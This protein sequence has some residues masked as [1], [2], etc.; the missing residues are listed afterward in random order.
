VHAENEKY[1]T[2]KSIAN[3][4]KGVLHCARVPCRDDVIMPE[5]VKKKN[6]IYNKNRDP[7][8]CI[9]ISGKRGKEEKLGEPIVEQPIWIIYFLRWTNKWM[10]NMPVLLC[11]YRYTQSHKSDGFFPS[12]PTSIYLFFYELFVF[13][14]PQ[15]IPSR[16]LSHVLYILFFL[17]GTFRYVYSAH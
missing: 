13:L 4:I 11:M 5:W 7:R 8:P 16:S 14:L 15:L 1:S 12:F 10:W 9:N 17:R 3:G 2:T 6:Y